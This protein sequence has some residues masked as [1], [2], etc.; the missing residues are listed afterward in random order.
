MRTFVI[1]LLNVLLIIGIIWGYQSYAMEHKEKTDAYKKKLA[2]ENLYQNGVYEGIGQGFG[3]DIKVQVTV[4][5]NRIKEIVI[6][7]AEKETPEYLNAAKKLLKDV[8]AA[9]SADVDSVSGATL[10]SNG[11]LEGV[12]EALR[13]SSYEREDNE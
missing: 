1:K 5:N 3:G 13:N 2:E 11:I 6:L 7:S 10:S 8:V 9:Q 12:K 4:E